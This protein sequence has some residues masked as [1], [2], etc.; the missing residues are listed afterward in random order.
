MDFLR[1]S[2][3]QMDNK[4]YPK[5]EQNINNNSTATTAAPTTAEKSITKK[6]HVGTHKNKKGICVGKPKKRCHKETHRIKGRCK[7]KKRCSKGTHRDWMTGN[8]VISSMKPATI[9]A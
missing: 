1:R 7:S 5:K 3:G 9:K 6:C 8:C 2:F 4:P